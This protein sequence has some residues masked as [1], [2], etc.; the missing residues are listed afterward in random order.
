[1]RIEEESE[2]DAQRQAGIVEL[3][4]R[5]AEVFKVI[6]IDRVPECAVGAFID[7]ARSSLGD[8][9]DKALHRSD[10]FNRADSG[11]FAVFHRPAVEVDKLIV[12]LAHEG[13]FVSVFLYELGDIVRMHAALPDVDAHFDHVW[14]D[15][16]AVGIGMVYDEF[17][18]VVMVVAVDFFVCIEEEFR[19][20]FRAEE[21]VR[22]AAP[23]VVVQ[24]R[25]GMKF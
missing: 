24:N 22:L 10:A 9:G 11:F 2:H 17:H 4:L 13:D 14:D 25:V 16:G 12:D 7:R 20:H 23:V 15:V 5:S 8:A 21:G 1:M 18:S 19:E 6:L 3:F